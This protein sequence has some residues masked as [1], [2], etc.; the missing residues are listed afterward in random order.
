MN[1]EVETA[2]KSGLKTYK[3]LFGGDKMD[4]KDLDVFTIDHLFAKM[5]SRGSS[6]NAQPQ[7]DHCCDACSKGKRCR[8]QEAF[9]WRQAH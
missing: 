3:K 4:I 1:S 2:H 7:H 9:G 8:D 5:E 6:S